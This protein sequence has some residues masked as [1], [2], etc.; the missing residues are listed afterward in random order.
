M[1]KYINFNSKLEPLDSFEKAKALIED[2][3]K[4][5]RQPDSFQEGLEDLVVVFENGWFDAALYVDSKEQFESILDGFKH[6]DN[7]PRTWLIYPHASK[8]NDYA[9]DKKI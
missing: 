1:S 2:G 7:R 6:G 4:Y 9:L 3:A 5:I 8:V